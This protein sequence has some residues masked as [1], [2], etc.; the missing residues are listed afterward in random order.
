MEPYLIFSNELYIRRLDVNGDDPLQSVTAQHE[1][2]H[3]LDY[4][5]TNRTIYFADAAKYEISSISFDGGEETTVNNQQTGSVEGTVLPL[6]L[7]NEE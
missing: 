4:D 3:A 7:E 2:T 5:Y 1:F 6:F